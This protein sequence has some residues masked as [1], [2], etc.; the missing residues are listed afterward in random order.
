MIELISAS[1]LPG[2]VQ[3]YWKT[4]G[5]SL[6]FLALTFAV[7]TLGER[8]SALKFEKAKNEAIEEDRKQNDRLREEAEKLIEKAQ[9][10]T[11]K[12]D[13]ITTLQIENIKSI[14]PNQCIDVRLSDIGLQ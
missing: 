1:F 7:Y 9:N 10:E 6:L 8:S 12:A 13:K 14:R 5:L 3:K 11:A 2:I 4:I